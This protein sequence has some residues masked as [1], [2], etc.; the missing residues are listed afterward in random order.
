MPSRMIHLVDHHLVFITVWGKVTEAEVR[1]Y[2]ERITAFL[3]Q[4]PLP[5]VH[6]IYDYGQSEIQSSLRSL[7]TIRNGQHPKTGWSIF[8]GNPNQV[9]KFTVSV[10]AQV[11]GV[12]FRL[13]NTFV[14]AKTLIREL[15]PTLP[16]LSH[17]DLATLSTQLRTGALP[18][19]LEI[20]LP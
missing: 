5:K 11:L 20:M 7:S 17:F 12:R 15:D 4:N 2:D 6:A 1:L 3:N 18:A 8:V 14:E 16:D 13:V 9:L 19:S 10:T